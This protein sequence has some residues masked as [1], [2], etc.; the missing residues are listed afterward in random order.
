ML[1]MWFNIIYS[2]IQCAH[3]FYNNNNNNNN[4]ENNWLTICGPLDV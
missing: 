3:L 2:F 4:F 1:L